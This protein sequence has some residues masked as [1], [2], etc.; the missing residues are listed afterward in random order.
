MFS[1]IIIPLRKRPA[2]Q[3]MAFRKHNRELYLL[4][5]PLQ[6]Q[7]P[8]FHDH[9]VLQQ[10][11]FLIS[12]QGCAFGAAQFMH[13]S[14]PPNGSADNPGNFINSSLFFYLCMYFTHHL[15]SITVSNTGA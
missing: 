8:E 13:A 3:G 10:N 7:L 11:Q 6:R 2:N 14:F 1:T 5:S 15:A 4:Y 9:I 12:I